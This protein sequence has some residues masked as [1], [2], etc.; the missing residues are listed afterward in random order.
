[1]G[2]I[3]IARLFPVDLD[4]QSRLEDDGPDSGALEWIPT[5]KRKK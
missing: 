2:N 4:N 1:M 3:E 5:V